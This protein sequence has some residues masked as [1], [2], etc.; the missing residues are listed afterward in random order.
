MTEMI[1]IYKHNQLTIVINSY[2]RFTRHPHL[3]QSASVAIEMIIC[4]YI[5]LGAWFEV[6]QAF[7]LVMTIFRQRPHRAALDAFAANAL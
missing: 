3:A 1:G 7:D 5:F 2:T 6:L 4:F